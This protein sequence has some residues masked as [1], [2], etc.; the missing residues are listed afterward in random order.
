MDVV[1]RPLLVRFLPG[2][3]A[4]YRTKRELLKVCRHAL[5]PGNL[6]IEAGLA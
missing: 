3:E 6:L 1:G 5:W 2:Q 4:S